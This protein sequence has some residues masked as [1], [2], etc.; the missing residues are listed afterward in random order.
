MKPMARG[1]N[2]ELEPGLEKGPSTPS[3]APDLRLK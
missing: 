3:A 2:G 1:Q